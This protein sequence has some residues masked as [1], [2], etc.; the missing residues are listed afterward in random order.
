MLFFNDDDDLVIFNSTNQEINVKGEVTE[1]L[2]KYSSTKTNVN[3]E[4]L[5][6]VYLTNSNFSGENYYRKLGEIDYINLSSKTFEI[7]EK[8]FFTYKG[9]LNDQSGLNNT[10]FNVM[11]SIFPNFMDNRFRSLIDI[12]FLVYVKV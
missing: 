8:E 4:R 10:K 1:Y 2:V 3:L 11:Q 12:D 6:K 7:L 5:S 9:A